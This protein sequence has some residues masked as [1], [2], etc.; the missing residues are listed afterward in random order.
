MS[1]ITRTLKT[2]RGYTY[3][4]EEF[5][6][7]MEIVRTNRT[8]EHR[9][10]GN[11]L[12]RREPSFIG[13]ETYEEAEEML[14]SGWTKGL[15]ELKDAVKKV[16][17]AVDGKRISTKNE[18]VGFAPIVPLAIQGV[19]NCMINTY[20]KPIKSKVINIYYSIGCSCGVDHKDI[21]KVGM[22][23]MKYISKLE[24]NGYRVRLTALQAYSNDSSADVML[25]RL[26]SENQPMDLRRVMFPMMHPAMFRAIG[27]GWFER[28]PVSRERSGYG[29]PIGKSDGSREENI[30]ELIGDN[31]LF[32]DCA[33]YVD[34]KEADIEKAMVA[35]IEGKN[36]KKS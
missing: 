2:K 12:T 25:L 26:K 15:S 9:H 20:Y 27:F 16:S 4:I 19:P 6:N 13:V 11:A 8:R 31:A 29:M 23:A 22:V 35:L 7:A 32:M 24:S 36:K 28:S 17:Y 1:S 3:N 30:R 34:K 21:L 14:E 5:D 10:N 18:I 33:D